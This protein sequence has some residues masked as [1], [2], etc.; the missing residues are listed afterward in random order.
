MALIFSWY[1]TYVKLGLYDDPTISLFSGCRGVCYYLY[2]DIVMD[3][4]MM[5]VL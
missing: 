1:L 3:H 5:I 4:C 2:L